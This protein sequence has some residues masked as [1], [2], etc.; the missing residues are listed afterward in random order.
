MRPFRSALIGLAF[1]PAA[2]PSC[3]ALDDSP[4]APHFESYAGADYDS[5]SADLTTSLVW[6]PFN[7][8]NQPGLR[9]KLDGLADVYGVTNASI[10]GKG[11]QPGDIMGLGDVMAGYQFN[12]GPVWIKLY[13]GASYELQARLIWQAGQVVQQQ[14]WGAA[15]AVESYWQA[16]D[17]VWT[18]ANISWLQPGNTTS[19][20]SR[21]AY[22]FYH[23]S[24]L[25]ISA[26]GEAGFTL[27]N[28]DDFKE[29]KALDL[30]ND[31]VRGGGLLNLRYGSHDLSLSGGLSQ[32]NDEAAWRPYATIRYG[33]QF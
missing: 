10:F 25:K 33:R 18:S 13:A 6:S 8:I 22:E 1:V 27:S 26:G 9:I 12:R 30:Y 32:A 15:A 24:G 5:R 23:G 16:S 3:W 4:S 29:G 14:S 20:Y 19:I 7:P 2:L 11:F 31:Y 21:A 17:R 28:A